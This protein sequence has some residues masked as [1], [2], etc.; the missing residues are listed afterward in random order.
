M[1]QLVY[2][3]G[4]WWRAA[5]YVWHRLR[6]LPDSPHRIARGIGAGVFV[7]FTPLFGM[8][9]VLAALIA[10][11]IRGNVLAA[12]LATFFGNPLTFPLIAAASLKLGA[13]ILG[14]G[15]AAGHLEPGM[16]V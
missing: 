9:F 11:L 5:T 15:D 4:G 16:S 8:H 2:P 7:S 13:L 10:L 14:S 1:R 3:R 12:V 6:R